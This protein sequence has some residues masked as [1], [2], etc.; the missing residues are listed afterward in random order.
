MNKARLN[1]TAKLDLVARL[2]RLFAPAVAENPAPGHGI[3]Q[4][5]VP[6]GADH[7]WVIKHSGPN[8]AQRRA[9]A[10]ANRT[11]NRRKLRNRMSAT[12]LTPALNR[13]YRKGGAR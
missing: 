5:R 11:R 10:L 3:S 1:G 2:T 6:L 8:Y 13:P 12:Q 7:R 9:Y 4:H